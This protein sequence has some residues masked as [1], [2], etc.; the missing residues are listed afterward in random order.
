M[1]PLEPLLSYIRTNYPQIWF[2]RPD[3]FIGSTIL[4]L[5][6][7]F[8]FAWGYSA[9]WLSSLSL[10]LAI[11]P[12]L[13]ISFGALA[14]WTVFLIRAPKQSHIAGR[15]IEAPASVLFLMALFFLGITIHGMDRV[16]DAYAPPPAELAASANRHSV[17]QLGRNSSSVLSSF[18]SAFDRAVK[19]KQSN[20]TATCVDAARVF[21]SIIY[22]YA[23]G[24]PYAEF[25]REALTSG[26]PELSQLTE[27]DSD[28]SDVFLAFCEG[29]TPST[30]EFAQSLRPSFDRMYE[31]DQVMTAMM[32]TTMVTV[33]M[34]FGQDVF[35]SLY[36]T[37]GSLD[38]VYPN[39]YWPTDRQ[40]QLKWAKRYLTERS[41]QPQNLGYRLGKLEALRVLRESAEFLE[42]PRLGDFL[43]NSRGELEWEDGC[44]RSS[45]RKFT[46]SYFRHTSGVWVPG[47]LIRARMPVR[48]EPESPNFSV[49]FYYPRDNSPS[50]GS[51]TSSKR[52]QLKT[53][54]SSRTNNNPK[55]RARS[56]RLSDDSNVQ[57]IIK[58]IL[59]VALDN[60][61]ILSEAPTGALVEFVQTNPDYEMAA[62]L[63]EVFRSAEIEDSLQ[64]ML[65]GLDGNERELVIAY[66]QFLRSPER[67]AAS[68]D[69]LK[70]RYDSSKVPWRKLQENCYA[71]ALVTRFFLRKTNQSIDQACDLTR[72]YSRL[73][74]RRNRSVRYGDKLLAST[75]P[76]TTLSGEAVSPFVNEFS[77]HVFTKFD[78]N[79][80]DG[81][82]IKAV[83]SQGRLIAVLFLV[84]FAVIAIRVHRYGVFLLAVVSIFFSLVISYFV[85][86]TVDISEYGSIKNFDFKDFV[87]GK[88]SYMR[89]LQFFNLEADGEPAFFKSLHTVLIGG[90]VVALLP[91]LILALDRKVRDF[92][93]G[94]SL[95]VFAI[96]VFLLFRFFSIAIDDSDIF[97]IASIV[98]GAFQEARVLQESG[99]FSCVW[100]DYRIGYNLDAHDD[101]LVVATAWFLVILYVDLFFFNLRR[102]LQRPRA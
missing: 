97:S 90:S 75:F 98:P 44:G 5:S 72:K 60:I 102:Y 34:A 59:T 83:T 47:R 42:R 26:Y 84:A 10:L 41:E 16:M 69:D 12:F 43:K 101:V 58:A 27:D 11:V 62:Q 87:A 94:S 20:P 46:V 52:F 80:G 93:I 76:W 4:T 8:L 79:Y 66:E 64:G 3:V 2:L 78:R 82:T 23:Y 21:S 51:V 63:A 19:E 96:A 81:P 36:D 56:P 39:S 14:Y 40:A 50:W 49:A 100:R 33:A 91:F 89:Y 24:T 48:V 86:T 70:R 92:T 6:V 30:F 9:G 15:S 85:I 25:L 32:A 55:L 61:C 28:I 74:K 38:S 31:A 71:D 67:L 35:H 45:D 88:V 22:R 65:R 99:C 57:P 7:S 37:G 77:A 29:E 73:A 18:V 13:L 54:L 68:Y 95:A 17:D 53:Y 1:N